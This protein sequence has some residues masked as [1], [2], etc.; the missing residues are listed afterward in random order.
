M[1][2]ITRDSVK[3]FLAGRT[4]KRQNMTVLG[5][6]GATHLQLHG[7]TIARLKNDTLTISDGG[8]WRTNTTRERLNGLL[9]LAG[10]PYRIKQIDFTWYYTMPMFGRPNLLAK[11]RWP[12]ILELNYPVSELL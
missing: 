8:G 12:G 1:K 4:F 5:Y 7:N 11:V 3:A 2:Q 10:Y 9:E 6:D